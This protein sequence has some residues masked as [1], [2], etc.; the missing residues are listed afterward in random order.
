MEYG[1]MVLFAGQEKRHRQ[2]GQT[3]GHNGGRRGWD[4][5]RAWR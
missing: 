1:K 4:K 3:Y 5:L 2:R